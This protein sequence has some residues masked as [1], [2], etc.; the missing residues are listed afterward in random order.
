MKACKHENIVEYIE[1][2]PMGE[3][4]CIVSEYMAGG[5]L[6]HYLKK[7]GHGLRFE[8]RLSY[9]LQILKAMVYLSQKQIVHRDLAARN[10]L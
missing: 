4:A 10:C 8:D 2:Y 7:H 9:I 5:D 6:E 3:T 1:Y